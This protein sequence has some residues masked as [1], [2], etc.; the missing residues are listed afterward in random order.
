MTITLIALKRLRIFLAT[1]KTES[2]YA[3]QRWEA[4][5]LCGDKG[6]PYI[7][8]PCSKA[9]NYYRSSDGKANYYSKGVDT[10]GSALFW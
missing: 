10:T 6:V 2:D 4:D 1:A 8:R 7:S 5:Y 3:L 9:L